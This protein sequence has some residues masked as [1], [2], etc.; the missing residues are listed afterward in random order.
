[1]VDASGK[2]LDRPSPWKGI[3]K[4]GPYGNASVGDVVT[5]TP[6]ENVSSLSLIARKG[7]ALPSLSGLALP[8]TGRWIANDALR[9]AA[10]GSRQWRVVAGDRPEGELYREVKSA[11]GTTASV[12]DQSHGWVNVRLSGEA[13]PDVLSKGSSIDFHLESFGPGH[14]AATQIHHMMVHITCIED[15]GPTYEIQLFR[16][17]AGSFAAWLRDSAAEFGILYE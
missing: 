13:T 5:I 12:I 4:P 7:A 1:M 16:S 9:I 6:L 3:M 2:T 10:D 14:C 15:A 17:M 11:V 8:Q